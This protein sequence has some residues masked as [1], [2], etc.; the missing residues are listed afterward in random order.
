[1]Y[2]Y[3]LGGRLDVILLLCLCCVLSEQHSSGIGHS[4]C[5]EVNGVWDRFIVQRDGRLQCVF[6]VI[7]CDE[8]ECR[9]RCGEF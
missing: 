6:L 4:K 9:L 3:V 2:L 7:S 5:G 8:C 1:M